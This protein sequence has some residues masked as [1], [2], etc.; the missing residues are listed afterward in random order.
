MRRMAMGDIR[1]MVW[2]VEWV[3]DPFSW[4]ALRSATF[5]PDDA[6]PSHHRGATVRERRDD[7]SGA[8]GDRGRRRVLGGR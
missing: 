3:N 1:L 7:L 6:V 4:P 2:N 8:H 5:K